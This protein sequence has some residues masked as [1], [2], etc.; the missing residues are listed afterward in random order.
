MSD[1]W[2]TDE[3]QEAWQS[4]RMMS[5][6]LEAHIAKGLMQSALSTQDY[7]VLSSLT[8]HD[9]AGCAPKLLAQ[10]LLWSP[11]RL[12]HHIDRME[13]RGLVRREPLARGRSS[14][15]LVTREG[16]AAIQAAAPA[17]VSLVRRLFIDRLSPD[18]LHMLSQFAARVTDAL[19]PADD[20]ARDGE[21]AAKPGSS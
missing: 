7:D 13:A 8:A 18:E 6:L 1:R 10:H 5:R 2:L 16:R 9:E 12:S 17:H 14:R 3:Q 4:Y 11:S 19:L 20:L 15:V 21:Q